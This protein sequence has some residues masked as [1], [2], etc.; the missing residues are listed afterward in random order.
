MIIKNHLI[1][2]IKYIKS[3]N[4]NNRPQNISIDLLVIHSISLPP[5]VYGNDHIEQ[6][7]LNCLDSSLDPFYEE[8]KN[9]KVSAHLLIKRTGEVIQFVPFNM[10]AWHAG[11]STFK[12][13]EDCNSFSIGV[14]LE[15]SEDDPFEDIQY[16]KLSEV[17]VSLINEYK[18]I[19]KDN[20]RGHS[21][22]APGR[23]TDPGKFF[24]WKKYLN[25]V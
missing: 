1:S 21:D 20:I 5:K 8:I 7:F 23:K 19:T 3:P 24:D 11:E 25:N 9:L 15:G 14:E 12:G 4:F 22:I 2:D 17:T 13:R 10:R 18:N 6:F 16:D